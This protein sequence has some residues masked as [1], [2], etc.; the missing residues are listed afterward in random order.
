MKYSNTN[1]SNLLSSAIELTGGYQGHTFGVENPADLSVVATLRS[2]TD[3][4]A[5]LAIEKAT[6]GLREWKNTLAKDRSSR[7]RRWADLMLIN[8]DCLALLMTKEQGKPLIEARGEVL[9]AAG[10]LE[11]FA[12]EAR[13][14]Y[15]ETIPTYDLNKRLRSH[16]EPVGVSAAITPW[17]F[18]LAMIARKAA[19]ALAA[20]CTMLVKP[21]EL[22]PLSALAMTCLAYEAGIPED[23]LITLAADERNSIS[24]GQALC[25]STDI[26][27]LSFTGS[28]EVGRILMRQCAV[29][30]KKLSLELGGNAPFIVF[31]DA[32][33]DAAIRGA[34]LSKFRNAGQ[35]CVC[36]NRFLVQEGI[37][38]K[39][40][41]GL[42]AAVRM[43]KTG[44][45]EDSETD[46]GPLIDD[47]AVEKVRDLVSDALLRGAKLE[48][49]GDS[50]IVGRFFPATVL[51]GIC[52]ELRIA[53]EEIF[54]PVAAVQKFSSEA[55]AIRLANDSEYGLATYFY[56]ADHS[57]CTRV[58]EALEYGMVGIN[59]GMIST[60][61]APFGGVKQSGFGRE[62]GRMGL[63]E[64]LV[65]KYVC[66]SI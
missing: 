46:I 1:Y 64:Y 12:E 19:P 37:H 4:D 58:S 61:V 31:D 24:I 35:T 55:D 32:D 5:H 63:E 23:A 52:P 40:V 7:L 56:S 26:R 9:Y 45:G 48:V 17:N 6:S 51:S 42:S 8:Q 33:V 16:K 29:S 34:I 54:G 30:L 38:D 43:L 47:A 21:S 41:S 10:Y 36:S 66:A 20:G 2:A 18:P 60:E 53:R 27:K 14:S 28:T 50:G 25:D 62:G 11:W 3:V 39:F 15:G 22:T 59:T 65:T 57:R 49:G 44:S 13:R